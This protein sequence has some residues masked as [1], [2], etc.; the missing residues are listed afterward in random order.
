MQI[1]RSLFDRLPSL[2]TRLTSQLADAVDRD[3]VRR[4]LQEITRRWTEVEESLLNEEEQLTEMHQIKEHYLDVHSRGEEWLEETRRLLDEL[5]TGHPFDALLVK[6]KSALSMF[7]SHFDQFQRV[8]NRWQRLTPSSEV[9]L[10]LHEFDR[11]MQSLT[12]TRDTLQEALHSREK[13]ERQEQQWNKQRHSFEQWLEHFQRTLVTL[14]EQRSLP[15]DE[16]VRRLREM[17]IELNKRKETTM[18]M[19]NEEVQKIER[20]QISLSQTE[21]T[22]EKQS[23]EEK[24]LRQRLET[25]TDWIKGQTEK[26]QPFSD[27]GDRE[28]LQREYQGLAQQRQSIEEKA[29]Q[30]ESL[31]PFPQLRQEITQLKQRFT[32]CSEELE[33]RMTFLQNRIQVR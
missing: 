32:D 16:K 15:I 23:K 20:V 24:E 29:H 31:R 2:V 26:Y 30:I 11:W 10:Q 33:T 22:Y 12:Q 25:L 8:R 28:S 6:G 9:S 19:T 3:R 4:R 5:N 21:E 7:A 27:K 14:A 13:R 17:K 1:H 18:T